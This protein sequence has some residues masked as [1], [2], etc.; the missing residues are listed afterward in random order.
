MVERDDED[1]GPVLG[2]YADDERPFWKWGFAPDV[3]ADP[4][5]IPTTRFLVQAG[6]ASP[7]IR[8]KDGSSERVEISLHEFSHRTGVPATVDGWY[9]LS[10]DYLGEE[11]E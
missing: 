2:R 4:E 1:E 9:A 3:P 11:L 7:V 10:G 5:P 6:R 8:W